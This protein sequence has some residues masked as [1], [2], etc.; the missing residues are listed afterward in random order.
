MLEWLSGVIRLVPWAKIGAF[1]NLLYKHQ[2]TA[3][4]VAVSLFI[5][6]IGLGVWYWERSLSKEDA[7]R[8]N[9]SPFF[10]RLDA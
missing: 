10:L 7:E 4:V 2:R 8:L 1:L 3:L 9:S 6:S 5:M